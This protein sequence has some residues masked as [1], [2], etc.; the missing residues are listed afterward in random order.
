M[1]L[2]SQDLINR[3]Y[4]CQIVS[5]L[6]DVLSGLS[7]LSFDELNLSRIVWNFTNLAA[8]SNNPVLDDID[9]R[10][11][12][13]AL[14]ESGPGN[15]TI[16][17]ERLDNFKEFSSPYGILMYQVWPYYNLFNLVKRIIQ[18]QG[19]TMETN[20]K[21]VPGYVP[22]WISMGSLKPAEDSND[23]LKGPVVREVEIYN[24]YV[25]PFY[26]LD[27]TL[28]GTN[29]FRYGEAKFLSGFQ[30]PNYEPETNTGLSWTSTGAGTIAINIQVN[31]MATGDRI[32]MRVRR[33][34]YPQGVPGTSEGVNPYETSDIINDDVLTGAE[35]S[36]L[37]G[38]WQSDTI[39]V[40]PGESLFIEANMVSITGESTKA[41]VTASIDFSDCNVVFPGG[42]IVPDF[43]TTYAN[44]QE[45]IKEFTQLYCLTPIIDEV[46]RVIK[47]VTLDEL[48]D[49][50]A[51]G[52]TVDWSNKL[53][54][55]NTQ[56]VQ[57]QYGQYAQSNDISFANNELMD[58][59]DISKL[60][61]N[62]TN[63]KESNSLLSFKA[64]SVS[65]TNTRFPTVVN[66]R[67]RMQVDP[68]FY[69]EQYDSKQYGFYFGNGNYNTAILYKYRETKCQ[70][71]YAQKLTQGEYLLS[72]VVFYLPG[73]WDNYLEIPTATY[74]PRALRT[75]HFLN[76]YYKV[77]KDRILNRVIYFSGKFNLN[78]EDIKALDF[79]KPVYLHKFGMYFFLEKINNFKVKEL[80]DVTMLGIDYLYTE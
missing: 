74:I 68:K 44:Q 71:V 12:I 56:S 14:N 10:F 3:E 22:A 21:S 59:Q 55:N 1:E 38:I 58:Y 66:Y 57:F 64:T 46:N 51:S 40:S 50:I 16:E 78:L 24:S 60:T 18:F 19:Y 45:V 5:T 65:E 8:S 47:F 72:P 17:Q 79:F 20:V 9:Y 63:L 49:N 53:V 34:G 77:L 62:N 6:K 39:D 13:G 25:F 32:R 52:D 11:M 2:R 23:L 37:G 28:P 26:C 42:S 70:I 7:D 69:M 31:G 33:F 35:I 48:I 29:G 67:R 54:E 76:T 80:T 43:S 61:V 4:S 75:D 36:N 41:T 15:F 73:R 30:D 27:G